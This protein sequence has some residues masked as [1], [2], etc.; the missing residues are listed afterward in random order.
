MSD[1]Q[2]NTGRRRLGSWAM[3]FSLLIGM[4][5]FAGERGG[6]GGLSPTALQARPEPDMRSAPLTLPAL[7]PW[8]IV[9]SVRTIVMACLA[10]VWLGGC[11]LAFWFLM[12]DEVF[13]FH[14]PWLLHPFEQEHLTLARQLAHH[15]T[16]FIRDE[17][18]GQPGH[19]SE[20]GAFAN[21]AVVPRT[22]LLIYL[23][24][25]VPFLFS[26]TAW[27]WV[28]PFFAL[29]AAAA[30]AALVG[31]RTGSRVAGLLAGIALLLTAPVMIAGSGL[32]FDNIVALAFFL[33]ALYALD[34]SNAGSLAWWGLTSG[35]LF[36]AAALVRPDHLP[37]GMAAAGAICLSQAIDIRRSRELQLKRRAIRIGAV[38]GPAIA[39]LA[40][41]LSMNW[42]LYG[43]PS[44]TG[45]G[46]A[47]SAVGPVWSGS[48]GGILNNLR[49]F[50]AGDFWQ[51]SHTFMWDIGRAQAMLLAFGIAAYCVS[52]RIDPIATTLLAFAAFVMALDL[53]HVGAHGGV[54]PILVNSPPR[55]LLPVYAA[56]IV[57]GF[58]GLHRAASLATGRRR[59]LAGVFLAGVTI[60]IAGRGLQEAYGT[61]YGLVEAERS[62]TR[63]RQVRDFALQHP[64]DVFVGDVFTKALIGQRA[65]IPR[66]IPDSAALPRYVRDDMAQGRRV[67]IVETPREIGLSP[68]RRGYFGVLADAGLVVVQVNL[69]PPVMEVL[70]PQSSRPEVRLLSPEYGATWAGGATV[71][72]D[73]AG[74]APVERIHYYVD[75]QLYFTQHQ[76]PYTWSWDTRG[77]ADGVHRMSV[78]A[79]TASGDWAKR[80]ADF[81]VDNF[82]VSAPIVAITSPIQNA[83]V[84]GPVLIRGTATDPD[85]VASTMFYVDGQY[86]A[87]V[88]T[89]P[90][91]WDW[92]SYSVPDGVHSLWIKALDRNGSWST[93]YVTV[94]VENEPL[95]GPLPDLEEPAP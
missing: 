70:E 1:T 92:G 35:A 45:Y 71:I 42:L 87:T 33:W 66:L 16:L 32:A 28:S 13:F 90:Y 23:I 20:D 77:V 15:H 39:A 44:Q 78:V 61:R 17:W 30:A 2:R 51:M 80:D 88:T 54:L 8:Q 82:S 53:G 31:R 94:R 76:P 24:Y 62:T 47:P 74:R 27:L 9:V 12:P 14:A 52:R 3:P 22:T 25:S 49:R 26:E 91:E 11:A 84:S 38:A 64:D 40:L 37:S 29:A 68:D 4:I 85:G 75:G 18:F 67:F 79:V 60:L 93:T 21:G 83:T 73:A 58:E 69:T 89:E 48:A 57:L 34:R 65:I 5:A 55:Y 36:A 86:W 19:G 10:A 43:S 6:V 72:A 50:D 7:A 63:L 56:G 95:M 41:V 81:V 59:F 46:A